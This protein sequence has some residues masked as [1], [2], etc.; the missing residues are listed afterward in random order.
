MHYIT[1]HKYEYCVFIVNSVPSLFNLCK[2]QMEQISDS[3]KP[4]PREVLYLRSSP[5][6]SL[7]NLL[8]T[9][10]KSPLDVRMDVR[11]V[12]FLTHYRSL[13]DWKSPSLSWVHRCW[14]I[15]LFPSVL[16]RSPGL[17]VYWFSAQREKSPQTY[18]QSVMSQW[19]QGCVTNTSRSFC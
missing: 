14:W 9:W 13:S 12:P 8:L 11:A 15:T 3:Y 6:G 10:R 19:V 1:L 18:L 5:S 16:I 4:R 2:H 7:L 17:L